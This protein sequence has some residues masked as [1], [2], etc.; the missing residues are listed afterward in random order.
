MHIILVWEGSPNI[1]AYCDHCH[2][3]LVPEVLKHEFSKEF[4]IPSLKDLIDNWDDLKLSATD[5]DFV[6]CYL[7]LCEEVNAGSMQGAF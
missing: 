6:R 7:P 5:I 4:E 2:K 1:T 3:N